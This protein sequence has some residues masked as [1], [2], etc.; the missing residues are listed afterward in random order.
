MPQRGLSLRCISSH[1]FIRTHT[2]QR[3]YLSIS[4]CLHT[5]GKTSHDASEDYQRMRNANF[6]QRQYQTLGSILDRLP[7]GIRELLLWS[8]FLWTLFFVFKQQRPYYFGTEES[9][10]GLSKVWR[11][12]ETSFTT[13]LTLTPSA[14]TSN[15]TTSTS[16]R[17]LHEGYPVVVEK[18]LVHSLVDNLKEKA[19]NKE[20]S[21]PI[22]PFST[23]MRVAQEDC[24]QGSNNDE[25][26]SKCASVQGILLSK[27]DKPGGVF[28]R[29]KCGEDLKEKNGEFSVEDNVWGRTLYV[30]RDS[31]TGCVLGYTLHP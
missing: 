18:F 27:E 3:R 19:P 30:L 7:R 5:E 24:M 9:F 25:F 8:P 21:P 28:S 13:F 31:L 23:V 20:G 10:S 15:I 26:S 22:A 16:T 11:K 12:N 17:D 29:R 2:V 1:S 6:N 14:P 4:R